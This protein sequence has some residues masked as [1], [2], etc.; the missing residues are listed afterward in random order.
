[1]PALSAKERAAL[2]NTAFAYID[3]TGRRSLPIHDAG[4]VRSALSRFSQVSFE[5]EESRDR[6]RMRL[7]KAAKKHG[8]MPLGF[9]GAQ[10]R[11]DQ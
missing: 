10:L 3:S 8:I 11:P 6:A 7:L 2:P 4:H 9:V 1:M 5:N